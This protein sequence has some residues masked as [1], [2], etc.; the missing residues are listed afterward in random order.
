M[1]RIFIAEDNYSDAVLL[2][3][4]LRE[5]GIEADYELAED[6]EKAIEKLRHRPDGEPLPDLIVLDLNLPRVRGQEILSF[7]RAQE[8]LKH[9]A[10]V[11]VTS[12]G[13]ARDRES[14]RA[15]DA[16]FMKCSDWSD[17]LK[18]AQHLAEYLPHEPIG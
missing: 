5:N 2:R 13:A 9:I 18:L 7:I 8:A 15:A 3:E 6:G 1:S 16:Y 4:A 12:S 17:C 14:C 11:I 10:T